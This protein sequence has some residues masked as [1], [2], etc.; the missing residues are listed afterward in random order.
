MT[1]ISTKHEW[2]TIP[3]RYVCELNPTIG[4]DG[5][6][7]DDDVTFLPMNTVKSGY[8][9]PNADKFS[10]YASSYNVFEDGDI[11]LGKVTPCFEN[12]NIAIA[13]Q[14]VGGKGFG[15]SELLVSA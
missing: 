15:S 13:E 12:G 14:L 10:K 6:E 7:D 5:L 2:K 9:I 3:L 11:L 4:F 1:T 8:F